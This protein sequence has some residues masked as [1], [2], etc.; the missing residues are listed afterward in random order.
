M[1][2]NVQKGKIKAVQQIHIKRMDKINE[3]QMVEYVYESIKNQLAGFV[4][5][6]KKIK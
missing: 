2:N 3:T 6:S 1:L 4:I 5:W